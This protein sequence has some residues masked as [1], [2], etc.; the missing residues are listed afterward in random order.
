VRPPCLPVLPSTT[1]AAGDAAASNVMQFNPGGDLLSRESS[2]GVPSAQ[3]GLTTLFGMGRGVSLSLEP[4]GTLEAYPQ[5]CI[6]AEWCALK[7]MV[8]PSAD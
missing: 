6:A 7:V 5:D 2:L 1:K 4:P 3:R 8:K